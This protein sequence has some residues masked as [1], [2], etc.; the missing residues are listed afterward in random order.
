MQIIKKLS[1]DSAEQ[2]FTLLEVIAATVITATLAVVMVRVGI[3]ASKGLGRSANEIKATNQVVNLVRNMRYDVAGSTDLFAF[4]NKTPTAAAT[5]QMCSTYAATTG[6]WTNTKA[7][8]FVRSLFSLKIN[9]LKYTATE[10][11][12]SASPPLFL[13]T[14][15][16]WVGYEIRFNSQTYEFWRVTCAD[17][18]GSPTAPDGAASKLLLNL[19]PNLDPNAAGTGVPTVAG[20]PDSSFAITCEGTQVCPVAS[21]TSDV[22]YYSFSIPYLAPPVSGPANGVQQRQLSNDATYANP[23]LKIMSRKVKAQ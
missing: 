9:D 5:S 8:N 17:T 19:G 21:S 13:P 6:D 3:D 18:A 22:D 1:S 23:M 14:T 16:I 2:G 4:D 12:T 11:G 7:T 20:V 10:P 15:P